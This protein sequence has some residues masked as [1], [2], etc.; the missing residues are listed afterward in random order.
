MSES[1]AIRTVTTR[2]VLIFSKVFHLSEFSL[3]RFDSFQPKEE[4]NATKSQELTEREREC[5]T[6]VRRKDNKRAAL[7]NT[8]CDRGCI[9]SF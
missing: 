5:K 1:V 7:K 9:S 2:E 8:Y 4:D 6:H 3:I